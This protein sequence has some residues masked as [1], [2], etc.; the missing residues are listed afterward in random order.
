[1]LLEEVCRIC[2]C[3][4]CPVKSAAAVD[5]RGDNEKNIKSLKENSIDLYSATKSIYLQNKL[6]K[7]KNS[8][9]VEDDEWGNLDN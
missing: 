4:D 9:T 7:I 1:M 8:D 3:T 6:K 2:I 5:F